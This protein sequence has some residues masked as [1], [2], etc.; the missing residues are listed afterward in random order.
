M[1]RLPN[2][3]LPTSRQ[4]DEVVSNAGPI[5]SGRCAKLSHEPDS[6]TLSTP[7]HPT[8]ALQPYETCAANEDP[9]VKPLHACMHSA[10]QDAL[11]CAPRTPACVAPLHR[12]YSSD[13]RSLILRVG[14]YDRRVTPQKSYCSCFGHGHLLAPLSSLLGIFAC[15]HH[16]TVQ[17][18]RKS[19]PHDL[20]RK[21]RRRL[22]NTH[23]P[24]D[25]RDRCGFFARTAHNAGA[26]HNR[27]H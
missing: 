25:G 24:T 14:T 13:C 9:N 20:Y 3:R 6:S 8:T 17:S 7:P 12:R 18:E 10:R 19:G 15:V 2:L 5:F 1:L 16:E 26:S 21:H 11:W 4:L 27:R 23:R 22:Y